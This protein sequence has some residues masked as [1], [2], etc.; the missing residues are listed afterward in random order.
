MLP[1]MSSTENTTAVA[2]TVFVNDQ[3][4]VLPPATTLLRLIRDIGLEGRKGIA[5]AVNGA[6]V[7]RTEW[8]TLPMVHGDRVLIIQATQ[9]G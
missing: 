3:P 9:G 8:T 5:I 2:C 1:S 6:V 4:R 7:R